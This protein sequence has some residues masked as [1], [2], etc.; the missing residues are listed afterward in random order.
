MTLMPEILVIVICLILNAW[1]SGSEMALVTVAKSR[2]RELAK[3]GNTAAQKALHLREHPE[4][5]LSVIQVGI[6]LVGA[7]AAAVS[8]AE[9]KEWIHPI[10]QKQFHLSDRS[11]EFL[12]ITMVVIPITILSV[13]LGELVP[14]S[15]ALRNPLKISLK[16]AHPLLFLDRLFSP[17]VTLLEWSTKKI[18]SLF[19]RAAKS[20]P[21]P[22]GSNTVELDLLSSPTREYVVNLVSFEKKRVGDIYLPWEETMS[23][24]QEQSSEEVKQTILVSGHTRIPVRKNQEIVGLLNTKEFFAH[25]ELYHDRWQSLIR[26]IIQIED[27]LPLVKALRIMQDRRSHLSLVYRNQNLLGIVTMEDIFE[28][29]IGDIFDEDDYPPRQRTL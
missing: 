12:S 10:L 15:I 29:I 21:T 19:H 13:V 26:P 17:G 9:A 27:H 16:S 4:R 3:K 2:L 25:Y 22:Q 6:T 14:K 18:L 28:E 20:E 8:G 23:L 1:L 5:T 11:A 7:I 24:D